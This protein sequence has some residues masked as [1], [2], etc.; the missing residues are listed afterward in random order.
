MRRPE[1]M[2]RRGPVLVPGKGASLVA[3]RR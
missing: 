3:T 1:R 2:G